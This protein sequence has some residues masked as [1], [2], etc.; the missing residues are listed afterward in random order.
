MSSDSG[1]D[2]L[3]SAFIRN[4]ELSS[5]KYDV[6]KDIIKIETALGVVISEENRTLFLHR[7]CQ[8]LQLLFQTIKVQPKYFELRFQEN[9]GI[10]LL[11]LYR[12][13]Q[14]LS[15]EEI[16]LFVNLVKQTFAAW[17]IQDNQDMSAGTF[18]TGEIKQ[19]LL[20]KIKRSQEDYQNIFAF[21]DEGK[22]YV[23]NK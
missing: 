6:K 13:S 1:L 15:E 16:E 11:R 8:S 20:N 23:F 17:L 7:C 5:V 9:S 22:V 10:T 12:D 18:L 21:R 19:T 3:I 4:P 2:A 14:T